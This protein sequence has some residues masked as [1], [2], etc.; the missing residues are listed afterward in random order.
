LKW[1]NVT[2][3]FL[4]LLLAFGLTLFYVYPVYGF[5]IFV[6]NLGSVEFYMII[7]PVAYHMLPR[8]EALGLALALLFATS[9]TGVLKD[10]FKLPR[11]PE[12]L[13]IVREE[14]YGFPSGHSTGSSAFWCYLSLY[15]PLAPLI[16]FSTVMIL[17]VSISRLMLGVHYPRDVVGGVIVG[18]TL[19]S[20]SYIVVR[21][22]S[23]RSVI[24]IALV[25]SF[26]SLVLYY[27]GFGV[28]EPPSVL[29]GIVL[30]EIVC[31]RFN[32]TFIAGWTYGVIG[33]ILA[34]FLGVPAL[35]V[36]AEIPL[37]SLT[38][39]TLAG[40]L[41]VLIPRIIRRRIRGGFIGEEISSS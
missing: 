41:A 15:K 10:V 36:K 34:L 28:L 21:S 14:G 33:S 20:I 35:R 19:A 1:F 17:S 29:L 3:L 25:I 5:W 31:S 9:L 26:A 37:L 40:F 38:L 4:A 7:L 12:G 30:G 13:W 23:L 39:L 8:V 24:S 27:A 32:L 6:S 18:V 11:P 2:L 16:A 22:L